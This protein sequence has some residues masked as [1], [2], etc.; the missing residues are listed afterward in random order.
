MNRKER[1][2]FERHNKKMNQLKES[3][4][5]RTM[6]AID[7]KFRGSG[8]DVEIMKSILLAYEPNP[9]PIQVLFVPKETKL[10]EKYENE[11]VLP[12]FC[13][14]QENDG[15]FSKV[16]AN[17]LDYTKFL[18]EFECSTKKDLHLNGLENPVA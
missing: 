16:K 11:K 13:Y 4:I 18:A 15:S 17:G 5:Y 10:F 1:R 2:E 14:L 8:T 7:D 6:K 3:P 9:E 12:I